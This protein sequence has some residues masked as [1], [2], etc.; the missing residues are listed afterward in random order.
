MVVVLVVYFRITTVGNVEVDI[1]YHFICICK[2]YDGIRYIYK[3]Y[4]IK[5]DKQDQQGKAAKTYYYRN[6]SVYKF[7]QL[8]NSKNKI[9]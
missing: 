1:E 2:C 6:P 5:Y 7:T 4:H 9:C 3:I 8:L